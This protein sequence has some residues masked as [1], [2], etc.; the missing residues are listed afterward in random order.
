[1]M[2]YLERHRFA[3]CIIDMVDVDSEK[4]RHYAMATS[5]LSRLVYAREARTLLALERRA[6]RLADRVVF[7]SGA[8]ADLFRRLAPEVASRVAHVD[9]GIDCRHFDPLPGFPD[10]FDET[11]AIVFAGTMDYRPNVD[12]VEWFASRVM[13]LLRSDAGRA[14][15][16]IVG[17]NPSAAVRRLA[18]DDIRV[19]GRVDDVRPYLA[20]AA[21][22]VAP[23]R[24][25]RGVQNKVLE[26]M[27]MA[28]PVIATPQ[29]IEGL[30]ACA[31][32]IIEARS[33]QVFAE[34]IRGVLLDRAAARERSRRGRERVRR[35]FGWQ[36][37]FDALDRELEPDRA[38]FAESG[39]DGSPGSTTG[40]L[41]IATR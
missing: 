22:F 37:S 6:A 38:A 28:A 35:D 13:P 27:A 4:W 19:T 8:E 31:G 10:P 36:S 24:I 41:S 25:A 29:A 39:G 40:R 30:E 21:A 17:A 20:H 15:F 18:R 23:M 12:A 2:S 5:G 1:M 34:K 7:V 3:R 9:N 14:S 16:W 26:A 11:S 32:E 33:A